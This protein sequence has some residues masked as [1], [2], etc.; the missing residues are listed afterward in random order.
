MDDQGKDHIGPKEPK[1]MNRPGQQQAH[2]M[3]AD[4]VENINSTNKG[5]DLPLANKQR[6][7]P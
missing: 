2:N 7:V 1:Q 6:I 4:D 5:R 3:P